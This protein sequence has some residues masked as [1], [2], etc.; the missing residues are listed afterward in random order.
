M[1][2]RATCSVQSDPEGSA[3]EHKRKRRRERKQDDP[4]RIDPWSGLELV[5]GAHHEI[6]KD[7]ASSAVM[8]IRV[9]MI[10]SS[11]LLAAGFMA[12]GSA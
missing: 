11:D 12:I 4:L 2:L 10:T 8:V 6:T 7:S 1:G 9:T 3:A 5:F